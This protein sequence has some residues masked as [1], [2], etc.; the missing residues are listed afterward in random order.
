MPAQVQGGVW[1]LAE[2]LV[3]ERRVRVLLQV[4]A[5]APHAPVDV[6]AP[7]RRWQADSLWLDAARCFQA[8]SPRRSRIA[9]AGRH[10]RAARAGTARGGGSCSTCWLC[11]AS[12][13]CATQRGA[14][15]GVRARAGALGTLNR[16]H[17][18]HASTHAR[19]CAHICARAPAHAHMRNTCKH[20]HASRM[21]SHSGCAVFSV[22]G[23]PRL[24][25]LPLS[26]TG[27]PSQACAASLACLDK[28]SG[29]GLRT[30]RAAS[31]SFLWQHAESCNTSGGTPDPWLAAA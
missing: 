22:C 18:G 14:A 21:Q 11:A 25:M 28:T 3:L 5:V 8:K 6:P 26:A 23:P 19:T 9:A 20:A 12:F 24:S 16:I 30:S 13:A 29:G 10:R 17:A 1:L 27:V 2:G 7:Q 4:G 31:R 15:A